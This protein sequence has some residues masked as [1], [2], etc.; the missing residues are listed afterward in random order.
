MNKINKNIDGKQNMK[1]TMQIYLTGLM[2]GC[3]VTNGEEKILNAKA[4]GWLEAVQAITAQETREQPIE[5]LE[6]ASPMRARASKAE[7]DRLVAFVNAHPE[8]DYTTYR[9]DE[10]VIDREEFHGQSLLICALASNYTNLIDLL[11]QKQQVVSRYEYKLGTNHNLLF[12]A[13]AWQAYDAMGQIVRIRPDL[14]NETVVGDPFIFS[15]PSTGN[16]SAL[17][18]LLDTGLDV[19]EYRDT[20]GQTLLDAVSRDSD[21]FELV[22]RYGGRRSTQKNALPQA[23]RE[24]KLRECASR[25]ATI[26]LD[27]IIFPGGRSVELPGYDMIENL[28]PSIMS[29]KW[30][31]LSGADEHALE[32]E[33]RT[34]GEGCGGLVIFRC[35]EGGVYHLRPHIEPILNRLNLAGIYLMQIGTSS[36]FVRQSDFCPYIAAAPL[37]EPVDESNIGKDVWRP[38][39]EESALTA[40]RKYQAGKITWDAYAEQ[41]S[42]LGF[43]APPKPVAASSAALEGTP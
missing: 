37:P 29:A 22:R 34:L 39:A 17:V 42:K 10:S 32:K 9:M 18:Q 21:W 24:R 4:Q 27:R 28:T 40:E 14:M 26:S 11:E 1:R 8:I 13:L 20:H 15:V 16:Q 7:E 5:K 38:S 30:R 35:G 2:L 12:R 6:Y 25:A 19:N 33:L 23:F 31:E 3:C 43:A 36:P 41:L